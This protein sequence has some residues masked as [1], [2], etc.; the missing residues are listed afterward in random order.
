MNI[1]DKPAQADISLI[2]DV[3]NLIYRAYYGNQELKTT[4]GVPS[5][6]IFGSISMILK[7]FRD[8]PI[9]I[10]PIWAYDGRGAKVERQKICPEYKANREQREFDPIPEAKRLLSYLPGL[11]IEQEL[12]E[13]DDAIAYAAHLCSKKKVVI[14]SSDRDLW[15][16]TTDTC[17]IFSPNKGRMVEE[18]DWLQE[19]HVVDPKRIALSKSLFGDSS[20]GLRG[21]ERIQKKRIEPTL[22]DPECTDIYKFYDLLAVKPSSL[23]ENMWQKTLDNKERIIN[24]YKVILPNLEGFGQQSVVRVL[25]NKENCDRLLEFLKQYECYSVLEE[26]KEIYD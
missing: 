17:K 21:I 8:F 4:Q 16:L 10:C 22:N 2:V 9:A 7:M 19:Y 18:T 26:A 1:V 11:H 15:A 3:S 23:S 25:K 13:G 12:R 14:Y 6:H 20:D 5:G 24:N